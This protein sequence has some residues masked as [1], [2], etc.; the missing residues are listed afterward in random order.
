M[1]SP[2]VRQSRCARSLIVAVLV[3]VASSPAFAHQGHHDSGPIPREILE[4]PVAL[5]TG[6][7]SMHQRVSTSSSQAQ[8]F[9]DQGLAYLH[10]YV[11]IEAAR[12]FYQ[13]LRIDPVLAM[14]Y[15]GLADAYVGMQDIGSA[16]AACQEARALSSHMR[17][18]EKAWLEI[19]T[20][21]VDFAEN[22]EATDRYAAYRGAISDALRANPRDPW[23]WVQRG[24]ADERSPFTHGQAGGEDTFAFYK[25]ALSM[26]PGNLAALHYLVHTSE[27]LGRIDDALADS[28]VYLHLAPAIP[29]A[30]HM[31]AHELMRRGHT[32]EA[33]QE[34]AKTNELEEAYYRS[35]K[36]PAAYDW[37]HAH[38]LQLLGMSY[39]LLGQLKL[40]ERALRQAYALPAST[41]FLAYNRKAWPEF[42]LTRGRY[43]EAL[44]AANQLGQSPYPMARLAAH[45]L[46]GEAL[47]G[48]NKTEDAQA[49][50]ALAEKESASLPVDIVAGLPYPAALRAAL[51]LQQGNL[52]EG[53]KVYLAVEQAELAMRGPDAWVAAELTLESIARN[54]RA[55]NDWQ[56][57]R[58]TAEQMI[59]HD[60]DYAGGHF[61][62]GLVAEHA[63][64]QDGARPMF[65]HAEQLWNHADQDLPELTLARSKLA[66]PGA[67]AS[68]R[69][70]P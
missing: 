49:E 28:A 64:E 48:L 58:F 22:P 10:S 15:L 67:R 36:I 5:R 43:Q 37:H 17:E 13:A 69:H 29:H 59:E 39:E 4:R 24:L 54:A 44:E 8:A 41:E 50:L 46:A 7:G 20:R 35:E 32:E 57:A 1:L 11:W 45:T 42:L 51:L 40:C 16:H 53:D 19:R 65:A 47:L 26:D 6:I 61:A 14:A 21:E 55:A 52:Q 70:A 3:L 31:R 27:D 2:S 34:F 60:A 66:A 12:S 33:V 30:H 9:Y 56:L 68:S 25:T 63:G 23:L 38:N 62:L 18:D